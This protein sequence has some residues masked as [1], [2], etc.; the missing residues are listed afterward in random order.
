MWYFRKVEIKLTCLVFGVVLA[1]VCVI[2]RFEMTFEL[3]VESEHEN[4]KSSKTLQNGS[5]STQKWTQHQA[6]GKPVLFIQ[7]H[8]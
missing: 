7:Y 8:T 4:Q 2:W 3:L 5:K 6:K 1:S